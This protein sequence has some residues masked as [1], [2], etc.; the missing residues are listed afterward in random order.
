[1]VE[2]LRSI[3][4]QV[5]GIDALEGKRICITGAGSML[6]SY[7][8]YTIALL[9]EEFAQP[10]TL[11][12]VTRRPAQQYFRLAPL[13]GLPNVVFVTDDCAAPSHVW[14]NEFDYLVY[15]ASPASSRAYMQFPLE[16]A[17]VNTSGLDHYLDLAQT[18]QSQGVVF[19]SSGQIYGAPPQ[20]NVPTPEDY[21][22]PADPYAPR[23]C[24]DEA[25]RF[26]EVLCSLYHRSKGLPVTSVRPIQVYGPG[27]SP[28]DERA[29]AEFL[30]AT[31]RGEAITLRS[32]G[33][34]LRAYCYLTDATVGLLA[35]LLHGERGIAYN[36]G[37]SQNLTSIVDLAEMIA[38]FRTPAIPVQYATTE[39]PFR[40]GSPPISCPDVSRISKLVGHA[41]RMSLEEGFSRC[42]RWLGER[43]S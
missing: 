7:L 31:F 18:F 21:N 27:L 25:K 16:T 41:P 4:E 43:D 23:A 34:D 12:A 22:S 5:V 19:I 40:Q 3:I 42:Y 11:L 20:E 36:I 13:M 33:S 15:A 37:S 29:F 14:D 10:C 24:Y 30:Y 1:M 6:T 17:R 39:D 26:G 35:A 9:N 38:A 8:A 32:T 2:D 28:D